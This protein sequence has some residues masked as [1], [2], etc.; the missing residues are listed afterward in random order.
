MERRKLLSRLDGRS[1]ALATTATSVLVESTLALATGMGA[2]LSTA[3]G[4]R[5]SRATSTGVA[6]RHLRRVYGM[7]E[8]VVF[9]VFD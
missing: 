8:V 4:A 7:T 6:D 1:A 5:V 9:I 2:M 3:L